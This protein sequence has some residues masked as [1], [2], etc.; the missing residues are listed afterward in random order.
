MSK[1][2]KDNAGLQALLVQIEELCGHFRQIREEAAGIADTSH[3]PDAALHLQ[4]VLQATEEAT[5]TIIDAM[6]TI[7]ETASGLSDTRAKQKITDEVTR[8]YVACSFQDISGQ[9]IKKV[10]RHLSALEEQLQRLSQ[11]ARREA[12]QAEGGDSL[13]NGPALNAEAPSQADVDALFAGM[14][15]ER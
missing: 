5:C 9:R 12:R 4:D 15:G 11:T 2:K 10:L 8:V 3:M 1:D 14:G 13:L 6:N 7:G